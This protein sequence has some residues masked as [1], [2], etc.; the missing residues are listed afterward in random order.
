MK[1]FRYDISFLRAYSV[2]VVLLYHF[3]FSVFKG[4]FIGVDIFFVLSGFLMTKIILNGFS[5][6]NF[7]LIN[8]YN[9]RVVRIVP[10]LLFLIISFGFIIY[11]TLPTQLFNYSNSAYSSSLFFSNIYY[12]LNSNYFDASSQ[13]NFLL[14][15]WSLSVEWQFYMVYPLLLM[16]FR[17]IYLKFP[18]KFNLVFVGL[19][20]ISFILMLYHKKNEPIYSFYIFYPRAWEMMV[21]GLAFL[22]ADYSKKINGKLKQIAVIISLFIISICVYKINEHQHTWPSY[23]TLIPV[24][25]TTLI[26]FLNI[27]FKLFRNKVITQLGNISYSLYLWHWPIYVI[28]LYFNFENNLLKKC[29]GILFSILLAY[30]SYIIIESKNFKPKYILI[31][32]FILFLFSINFKYLSNFLLDNSIIKYNKYSNKYTYSEDGVKQY[33][34]N[35]NHF[36]LN[37][38][39]KDFDFKSIQFDNSKKNIVLLGDSHAGMFSKSFENNLTEKNINFIQ[40][41]AGGTFPMYYE[42]PRKDTEKYFNYIFYNIL[43][44]NNHLIDTVYININ[45]IAYSREELKIKLDFL[46][47]Y[48]KKYNINYLFIGQNDVYDIDF[49]TYNYLIKTYNLE[50]KDNNENKKIEYEILLKS[51]LSDKYIQ[52]PAINKENKNNDLYIYDTNHLTIYGTDEYT[53]YLLQK[54]PN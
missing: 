28:F 38:N 21:G 32:T 2:I 53:K 52:L 42:K 34:L 51:I 27:D 29:V 16:I 44:I 41:T 50:I 18:K 20:L 45:Y 9:R 30:L 14:H 26:I 24:A 7:N 12:Y 22:Y 35:K 33:S 47:E 48:F 4:G 13:Y 10:P 8:F 17:R 1:D 40:L 46:I 31:C 6:N 54:T 37:Q 15:T 11:Y 36:G 49:P 23:L 5:K 25:L 3:K 19:I 39:I 43:N